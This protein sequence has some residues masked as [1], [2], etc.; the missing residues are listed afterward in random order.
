M[1]SFQKIIYL[2]VSIF[3]ISLLYACAGGVAEEAPAPQPTESELGEPS[4]GEPV[5]E[6]PSESLPTQSIIMTAV[7]LTPT[8][9][10]TGG[11]DFSPAPAI[12]ENRRL[13]LEFAPSIRLGDSTRIRMTLEVDDLGNI[14]PTAEIKGNVVKGKPVSIPNLYDTHTVIAETQL[15]MAG[16]AIDPADTISEPLHPGKSVTFYWTVRPTEAGKYEGTAWLHLHFIPISSLKGEQES[17]IPISAQFIT[18]EVRSLLGLSGGTARGLGAT[19][20]VVGAVIGF[21][22]I[23][24]IFRWLWRRFKRLK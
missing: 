17:R 2:G 11:G 4:E 9:P 23:D 24:D 15:N 12:Q 6:E 13:T 3:I 8:L 1:K 22:F 7:P 5:A 10:A 20:S 18:L 19:G 16:V 14:T 21:P